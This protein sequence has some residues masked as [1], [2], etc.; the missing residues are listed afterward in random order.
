M[1]IAPRDQN[2]FVKSPPASVCGAILYG[3]NA[4]QIAQ[5]AQDIAKTVVDDLSDVFNVVTLTPSDLSKNP[6]MIADELYS[7]SL[8]G[9][10]RLIWVKEAGDKITASLKSALEDLKDC[11]NFILIE[12][13]ALTPRSS[14]RKLGETAKNLAILACYEDDERSL[15]TYIQHALITQG[16]H[17]DRDVAPFLAHQLSGNRALADRM[18]EKLIT[19]KGDQ[20]AITLEDAKNCASDTSESSIDIAIQAA[21]DGRQ[22]DLDEALQILWGEGVSPVALTRVGQNQLYRLRKV[23]TAINQGTPQEQ[24]LKV[25]RPPLFF[26]AKPAFVQQLRRWPVQKID[27]ALGALLRLEVQC[28]KTGTPDLPLAHRVLA[29]LSG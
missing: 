3:P 29:S 2:S 8:M 5:M 22:R 9:G 17:P 26:K 7:Q 24:A 10:R 6:S 15:T 25:L 18:V 1:K 27:K 12:A 23:Q 11:P 19:Y 28:K 14:L 20:T 16:L 13:G 21:L 4:P